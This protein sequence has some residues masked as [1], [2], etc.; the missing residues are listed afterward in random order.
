MSRPFRKAAGKPAAPA[1]L[2]DWSAIRSGEELREQAAAD[3][4]IR[5]VLD[6]AV[7]NCA[8]YVHAASTSEDPELVET[9]CDAYW[10]HL[11]ASLSSD[12]RLG[13]ISL[14][15]SDRVYAQAQ[16]LGE[17]DVPEPVT[18]VWRRLVLWCRW[19][20][21]AVLRALPGGAS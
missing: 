19:L 5:A 12:D 14:L 15:L 10:D 7:T 1:Q 11:A 6:V 18:P 8:F 21:R 2:P 16:Q 9:W 13:A 17:F 3:A 20:G 4:R